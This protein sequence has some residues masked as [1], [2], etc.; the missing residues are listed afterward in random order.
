MPDH[1]GAQ[2]ARLT[3]T[4]TRTR[5]FRPAARAHEGGPTAST[6]AVPANGIVTLR[7]MGTCRAVTPSLRPNVL[8]NHVKSLPPPLGGY[9]PVVF[10]HVDKDRSARVRSGEWGAEPPTG[11]GVAACQNVC[12]VGLG[13][14]AAPGFRP[15]PVSPSRRE[16]PARAHRGRDHA[17][18]ECAGGSRPNAPHPAGTWLA[19]RPRRAADVTS[20]NSSA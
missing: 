5:R 17:G 16:R 9:C 20:E 6:P 18:P 19:R 10:C 2:R 1:W 13:K 11:R 4:L 15:R 14:A 3:P 8:H 7:P 12:P